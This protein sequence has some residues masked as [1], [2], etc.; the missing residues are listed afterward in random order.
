MPALVP[1]RA[2]MAGATSVGTRNV[3]RWRISSIDFVIEIDS[4]LDG[5]D[6]GSHGVLDARIALGVG[7]RA[8][9]GLV[10]LLD[11]GGQL[12]LGEGG[13]ARVDAGGHA[14]AGGRELEAV[15]AG[16]ELLAHRA[17]HL[18]GPVGLPADEP[19]MACPS[20]R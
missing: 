2:I 6:P 8:P 10:R 17:A 3:P 15:G 12:R 7:D 9:E 18:V 20:C 4:V 5:V 19:A 14:A 13:R 11:A 16:L 1:C